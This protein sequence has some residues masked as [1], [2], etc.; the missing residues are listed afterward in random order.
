MAKL[1]IGFGVALIA[2]A[3]FGYLAPSEGKASGTALIPIIFG[4]PLAIFGAVAL[5]EKRRALGMH[6]AILVSLVGGLVGAGRAVVVLI[7][8]IS[9]ARAFLFVLLMSAI[10]FLH[11]GLCVKSFIDARKRRQQKEQGE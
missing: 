5:N 11:V 9:N 8:G 7:T 4:A 10:C 3:L 6:I 2:L 1:T